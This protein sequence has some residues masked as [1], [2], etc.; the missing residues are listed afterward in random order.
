MNNELEKVAEEV[1]R[2]S[3]DYNLTDIL[4][5]S[6]V[7]FLTVFIV[8]V[9][10]MGIIMLISKLC[11]EKK[12][13]P[14]ATEQSAASAPSEADTPVVDTYTGV[15]LYG[16]SDK[17]AAI[18]MAIVADKLQKPLDNLRFISIKEVK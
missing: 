18:L 16:V 10:L 15:K 8:L 1:T 7:G 2:K 13:K 6:L 4:L 17:D 12:A 9:V 3:A 11:G 5:I 14:V